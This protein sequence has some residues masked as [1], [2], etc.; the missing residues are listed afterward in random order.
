MQGMQTRTP[1][2]PPGSTPPETSGV[3]LTRLLLITTFILVMVT[4]VVSWVMLD[5]AVAI[6]FNLQGNPDG[7]MSK[8]GHLAFSL[9]FHTIFLVLFLSIPLL[10]NKTPPNMVNLPNREFWLKPE[11]QP[12]LN[13]KLK[14]TFDLLGCAI[15][16]LFLG[17]NFAILQANLLVDPQLDSYF[18]YSLLGGFC[19]FLL[20]WVVLLYRE[21]SIPE[22]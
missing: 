19:L 9:I 8:T 12:E 22:Q 4:D 18:F 10:V 7:W 11:N 15:F 16:M 14:N 17:I 20:A 21:F 5:E 6:H 3:T 2:A 1:E 13:R